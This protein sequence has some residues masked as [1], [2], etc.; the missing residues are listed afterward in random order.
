M[1]CLNYLYILTCYCFT[2]M[3]FINVRMAQAKMTWITSRL[4]RESALNNNNIPF[5][6][7]HEAR[8]HGMDTNPFLLRRFVDDLQAN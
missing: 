3:D 8:G 6:R 7:S 1:N 5:A 2:E 4:R